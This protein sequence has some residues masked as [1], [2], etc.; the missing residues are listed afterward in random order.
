MKE[1]HAIPH[2]VAEVYNGARRRTG[3]LLPEIP[4]NLI[5]PATV[6]VAQ[7]PIQAKKEDWRKKLG[8]PVDITYD[9]G[10]HLSDRVT[11]E[12]HIIN[13]SS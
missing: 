3:A 11:F 13:L 2:E 12:L 1:G 7:D 4:A 9:G 8:D 10:T 6:F 5:L